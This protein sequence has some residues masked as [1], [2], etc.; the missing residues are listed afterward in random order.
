MAEVGDLLEEI[1][2]PMVVIIRIVGLM[3]GC[4]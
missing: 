1:T 3:A 4:F 2:D